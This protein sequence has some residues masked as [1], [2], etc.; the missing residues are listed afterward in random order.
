[1]ITVDAKLLSIDKFVFKL[2]ADDETSIESSPVVLRILVPKSAAKSLEKANRNFHKQHVWL[3][4]A[5]FPLLKTGG[6][7]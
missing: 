6:T 3:M 2:I 1:M 5:K 7:V 4:L